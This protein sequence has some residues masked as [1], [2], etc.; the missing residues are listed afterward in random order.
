MIIS[1]NSNK[2]SNRPV[3]NPHSL[4]RGISEPIAP[5]DTLESTI[6][7]EPTWPKLEIDYQ[8]AKDKSVYH[9]LSKNDVL[10]EGD[11]VQFLVTLG[12]PR[13]V[14]LFWYDVE[15]KPTVVWPLDSAKQSPTDK[16]VWPPDGEWLGIDSQIGA[17]FLLVAARDEPLQG[18]ELARFEGKLPY[19]KNDIQL[20]AVY[21]VGSPGL[22]RGLTGI[23][24]SRK[25]PLEPAF[26]ETLKQTFPAYHGLV[27]PHQAVAVHADG[28]KSSPEQTK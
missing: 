1:S 9:K 3:D 19:T 25:N 4:T 22:S 12:V 24:K 5:A 7:F 13:Y 26:E 2:V 15:G 10:H 17:E 6:P 23:T 14:Y 16:V 8:A 18:D 27:I 21:P 11:K 20:D 28:K